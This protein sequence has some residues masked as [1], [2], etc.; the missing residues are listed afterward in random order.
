MHLAFRQ[1]NIAMKGQV[2]CNDK[3]DCVGLKVH[4]NEVGITDTPDKIKMT[5][6]VDSEG[7]YTF[8]RVPEDVIYNLS[9]EK[10]HFCWEKDT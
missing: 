6:T 7:Y 10:K 1:K 5:T 3:K 4:M 9:I 2:R 8:N